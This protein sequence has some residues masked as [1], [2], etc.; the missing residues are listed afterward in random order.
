MKNTDKR[1]PGRP[2]KYQDAAERVQAFR[3]RKLNDGRRFDIYISGKASWRLTTLSKA[4]G[5]SRG[6]V[7]DRLLMEADHRYE[8]ILF[9]EM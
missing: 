7:I 3:K 4:W 1:R 9:P 6:D 5:C 8:D 2:R